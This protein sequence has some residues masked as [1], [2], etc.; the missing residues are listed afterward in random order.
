MVQK[1]ENKIVQFVSFQIINIQL[2]YILVFLIHIYFYALRW[3]VRRTKTRGIVD[4]SNK[5]LL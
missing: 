4:T 2:A 1:P 3:S 5:E